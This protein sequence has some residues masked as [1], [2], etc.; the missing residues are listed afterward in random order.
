MLKYLGMN[1]HFSKKANENEVIGEIKN[2]LI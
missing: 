2:I 1:K